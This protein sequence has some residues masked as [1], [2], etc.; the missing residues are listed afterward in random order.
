[1]IKKQLKKKIQK[2]KNNNQNLNT[3]YKHYPNMNGGICSMNK[4]YN[5]NLMF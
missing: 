5:S 3:K 1:M 2:R 4:N